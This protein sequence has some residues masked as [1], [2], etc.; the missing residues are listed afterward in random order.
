M[1][2]IELEI[3]SNQYVCKFYFERRINVIKGDSGTGKTSLLELIMDT[4]YS[5]FLV[6]H[7]NENCVTKNVCF[8]KRLYNLV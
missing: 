8:L 4:K 1:S 3:T 2:T 5:Y 7:R 6:F